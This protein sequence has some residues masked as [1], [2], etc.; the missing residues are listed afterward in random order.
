MPGGV[1]AENFEVKKDNRIN[2][3]E[4]MPPKFKKDNKDTDKDKHSGKEVQ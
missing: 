1:T 2:A 4:G 3:L